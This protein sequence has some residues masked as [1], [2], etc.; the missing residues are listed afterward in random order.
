MKKYI[1]FLAACVLLSGCGINMQNTDTQT[2]SSGSDLLYT[3]EAYSWLQNDATMSWDSDDTW[4][5]PDIQN[6]SITWNATGLAKTNAVD[7]YMTPPYAPSNWC[8]RE[9]RKTTFAGKDIYLMVLNCNFDD[10]QYTVNPGKDNWTEDKYIWW[11]RIPQVNVI[12][13]FSRK[14]T[15]NFNDL[16]ITALKGCVFKKTSEDK[17][18]EQREILTTGAYTTETEQKLL[19]DNSYLPCGEYGYSDIGRRRFVVLKSYPQI[20]FAIN[21]WEEMPLFES[22]TLMIK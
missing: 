9:A 14:N 12:K 17:D 1:Y 5:V 7:M 13:M 20:V 21:N 3:W 19:D 15:A 22:T 18:F 4:S 11:A 10:W 8:N 6:S 16:W 2:W